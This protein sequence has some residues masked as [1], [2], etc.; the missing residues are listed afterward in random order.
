ML[1][2]EL[3]NVFNKSY[4][5]Q[6]NQAAIFALVFHRILDKSG[7]DFYPGPLLFCSRKSSTKFTA[8]Q[9]HS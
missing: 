7:L 2:C 3:Y 8:R 5:A 1:M 6:A 4:N 9:V